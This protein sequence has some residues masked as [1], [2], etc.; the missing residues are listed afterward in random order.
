MGD[1]SLGQ[2]RS[3][4]LAG[5][6]IV[7][8]ASAGVGADDG[9]DEGGG[10]VRGADDNASDGVA[11]PLQRLLVGRA[12]DN[13]AAAGAALLAGVAEGGSHGAGDRLIEVGVVVDDDGVLAAHLGDDAFDVRLPRRRAGRG[14]YD[15]EADGVAA[16]KG[17][18]IDAWVLHERLADLAALARR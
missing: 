1:V 15:A 5:L 6:D 10:V 11:Q 16:G 8:D 14:L 2:E 3:V 7:E 12:N 9:R 13:E 18:D 17:D 4:A